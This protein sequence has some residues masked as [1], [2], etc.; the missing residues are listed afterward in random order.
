MGAKRLGYGGET[1]RDE[2]RGETTRGGGTTRGKT[3]WGRDVL[4]PV[5]KKLLLVECINFDQTRFF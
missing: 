2:N 3:S 5:V 1:T 4:L